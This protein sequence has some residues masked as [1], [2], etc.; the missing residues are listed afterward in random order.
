[1]NVT[2]IIPTIRPEKAKRCMDAIRLNAGVPAS[3]YTIL[4]RRDENGI[5]C[6]RMVEGM[7]ASA[8]T[9]WVMFLGDDTIPER[10]F[11]RS[12]LEAAAKLPDGWGVVGLNTEDPSGS[13]DRAHW[14]AHK[15]MLPLIA[16]GAF[17]STEYRHCYCDDEL[18]EIAQENGRWIF[19]EKARIRHDHPINGGDDDE[20]YQKAYGGGA[21]EDDRQTYQR[22]KV[23]RM[24][25]AGKQRLGIGWPLTNKILFASFAASYA[26]LQKPSHTFLLPTFANQVDVGQM[27]V[28]ECRNS[29]ADQA[30]M[31][32]CTH[33]LMMDTDQCYMSGDLIPRLLSH[34]LPVV[35]ARVHMRYPPFSPILRRWDAEAG[36]YYDFLYPEAEAAIESGAVVEVDATGCGCVLFDTRVFSDIPRPW[37]E[38]GKRANGDD[39][40]EDILFCEKL[41]GAGHKIF[42]DCGPEISHL[43]IEG[44]T[45]GKWQ[46]CHKIALAAAAGKEN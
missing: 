26:Q 22:R 35:A 23:D 32:G 34:N 18:K 28:P 27:E 3:R 2:I 8:E 20:G 17:F 11:L 5:G 40:G 15:K 9:P 44:I 14:M 29:L 12:A 16:G 10:D 33:L 46:L 7:A 30:R 43:S 36:R 42:V 31:K 6:P 21:F 13:N 41:R 39:V 37:F 4:M 24:W 25:A 45:A 38:F 19:A 1:M